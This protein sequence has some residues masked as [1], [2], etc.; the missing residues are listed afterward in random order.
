M[1]QTIPTRWQ[2]AQ[3]KNEPC[4]YLREKRIILYV[5][6]LPSAGKS[7]LCSAAPAGTLCARFKCPDNAA[8]MCQLSSAP[9]DLMGGKQMRHTN[10]HGNV[11]EKPDKLGCFKGIAGML[12]P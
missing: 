12:H 7:S 5:C 4:L 8:Q 2:P 11:T 6:H 3:W 10:Q 9:R 1:C